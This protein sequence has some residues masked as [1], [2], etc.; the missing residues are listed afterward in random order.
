VVM[1]MYA[2]LTDCQ[3]IYIPYFMCGRTQELAPFNH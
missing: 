1:V 2:Q 3:G